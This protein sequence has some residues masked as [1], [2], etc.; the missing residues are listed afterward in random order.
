MSASAR[1]H[2][3]QHYAS[4]QHAADYSAVLRDRT[5]SVRASSTRALS[6]GAQLNVRCPS[7]LAVSCRSP[8]T[9][10]P[11]SP[12]RWQENSTYDKANAKSLPRAASQAGSNATERVS[13]YTWNYV[14]QHRRDNKQ[15]L[16]Y[17]SASAG[18]IGARPGDCATQQLRMAMV[19]S[20]CWTHNRVR[21][22][23]DPPRTITN[24]QA[25]GSYLEYV[26]AKFWARG[27]NEPSISGAGLESR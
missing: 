16:Q 21:R 19:F 3:A 8:A 17:Q 12:A 4:H 10:Y 24:R 9:F 7:T 25:N 20:F 26:V 11:G 2:Q 5:A 6:R 15:R 23:T 13:E 18:E 1:F 14:R 27:R 22:D